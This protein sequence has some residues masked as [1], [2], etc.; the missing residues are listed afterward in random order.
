[1]AAGNLAGSTLCLPLFFEMGVTN[2]A[3]I[4]RQCGVKE[5]TVR[6]YLKAFQ[7]K[8]PVGEIGRNGR[9]PKVD[10]PGRVRIAQIVRHNPAITSQKIA[11]KVNSATGNS[12]SARTVRHTLQKMKY[13][14]KKP[15]NVPLLTKQHIAALLRFAR[16][17][18]NRDWTKVLFSDESFVQLFNNASRMWTLKGTS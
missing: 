12:I 13:K 5:S 10:S 1:M 6:N 2:C 7:S 17:N 8:K 3:E 16:N 15:R 11:D 14:A 4:E 18:I 9:P